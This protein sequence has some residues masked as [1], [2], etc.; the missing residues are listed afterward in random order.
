MI[1]FE[2]HLEKWH[3]KPRNRCGFWVFR[4]DIFFG[5]QCW[6]RRK[7]LNLPPCCGTR[8]VLS[9]RQ[10]TLPQLDRCHSLAFLLR[11]QDAVGS[12]PSGNPSVVGSSDA[13][14]PKRKGTPYGVP[15]RFGKLHR[16]RYQLFKRN[17]F[18][19]FNNFRTVLINIFC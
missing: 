8:A 14:V 6:L 18:C 12:L 15:F 4:T 7:D 3:E 9:H 16:F 5:S 1:S 2:F 19:P 11:P 17:S 13:F 10:A